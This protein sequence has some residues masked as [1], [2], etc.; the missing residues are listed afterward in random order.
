MTTK[1]LAYKNGSESARTLRDALGI[2]MLK[3]V[4]SK[5]TGKVGDTIIN[6]GSSVPFAGKGEA[7][8]INSP[9][10]VA[11]AANKLRTQEC[12]A[13]DI[14][15]SKYRIPH[16]TSKALAQTAIEHGST[17]VCR[18]KLTGNSGDG[19]VIATK[20]D[21]LVDAPL[22]TIYKKKQ[23]EYRVHV[24][25]GKVISVQRKARKND[26]EADK[27]NWK[28]RNLDGGF[29]F[30]RTGFDVPRAVTRAAK[31]AVKALGLDFGAADI[32][33]HDGEG[34][35]V[36]E[37]NTACGLS[38]S[39]LYDYVEAFCLKLALPVPVK[40]EGYVAPTKPE[41]GED[42]VAPEVAPEPV[43]VAPAPPAPPAPERGAIPDPVEMP[44]DKEDVIKDFI[45][46]NPENKVQILRDIQ[47]TYNITLR[48][49]VG[50]LEDVIRKGPIG[51]I[52][53]PIGNRKG[54]LRQVKKNLTV[55]DRNTNKTMADMAGFWVRT[56]NRGGGFGGL[57]QY[58]IQG[59]GYFWGEGHFEPLEAAAVPVEK[60]L[61]KEDV[62]VGDLLTLKNLEVGNK[63]G[64]HINEEMADRGGL[65]VEI[66][67]VIDNDIKT[68]YDF[69][70]HVRG[71]AN[72]WSWTLDMFE[73]F[74]G[75]KVKPVIV[76]AS[77]DLTRLRNIRFIAG[78][79]E[80][81]LTPEQ[82]IKVAGFIAKL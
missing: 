72:V 55:H 53:S 41:D 80:K 81:I 44:K 24:F 61:N 62:A 11:K 77:V 20:V 52:A 42:G 26:V 3:K 2:K 45:R 67:E 32:G 10:A 6:W 64:V 9:E 40:P 35:F 51:T 14:G 29:I 36:Y 49:A 21:E 63:N 30:A 34:T 69:R 73:G 65:M 54:T 46:R 59:V 68:R 56:T 38:G 27:V 78:N 31:V 5:W 58:T 60:V 48:E 8:Y 76:H 23:Q 74:G 33:Y 12:F 57:Y 16:M 70:G 4:G 82:Q 25:D 1:M 71:D 79:M 50:A 15:A 43:A 75:G 19:I 28:V 39:N 22:Y 47:R 18:T 13:A 37:V 66:T 7:V 17:V